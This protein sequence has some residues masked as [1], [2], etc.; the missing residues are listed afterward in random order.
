MPETSS[1]SSGAVSFVEEGGEDELRKLLRVEKN[2]KAILSYYFAIISAPFLP[3]T[4]GFEW[5]GD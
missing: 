1:Q 5:K 2:G 4:V 3:S